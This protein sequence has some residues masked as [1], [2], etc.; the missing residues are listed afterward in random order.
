MSIYMKA[1]RPKPNA[2]IRAI[3]VTEWRWRPV[4]SVMAIANQRQFEKT[5]SLPVPYDF[6][7]N[8][9][10]NYGYKIDDPDTCERLGAEMI[11]LISTPEILEDY[12]MTVLSQDG[13]FVFTYPLSACTSAFEV[14]NEQKISCFWVSEDA[15][16]Q[17]SEFIRDSGGISTP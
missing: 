16:F 3:D 4:R 1:L 10:G 13:S 17:M 7:E 15:L 11:D 9:D 6:M 12:G 5:G 14:K 8:L 2:K